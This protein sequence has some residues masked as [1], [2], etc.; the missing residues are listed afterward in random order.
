MSAL[1]DPG[2]GGAFCAA[3]R[4]LATLWAL[5]GGVVLL[6]VVGINMVS[7]IGTIFGSSFPGDFELTE[8]GVAVAAFT[9]LPFCQV[10]G[11]NVTADIFTAG[12]SKR[13][14]ARFTLLGALVALVFSVILIW[15]MFFGML[16]QR[17][18]DYTTAILAVPIW[19]A[20]LPVLVSLG[21]LALAALC[22]LIEEGRIASG[23][24]A[25][26]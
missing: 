13:W 14:V 26:V 19:Y 11:A 5:L 22:T 23:S 16:D 15:R 3:V 18:Y 21:L 7:V 1:R 6:L 4:K 9:F 24:D 17:A 10:S 20:F 8:M 25:H 2:H 12:A